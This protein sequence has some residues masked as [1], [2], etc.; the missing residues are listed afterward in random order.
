M[1][2]SVK[3]VLPSNIGIVPVYF[4]YA[5]KAFPGFL[6]GIKNR[7]DEI[8]VKRMERYGKIFC[9]GLIS[10]LE[11]SRK[12]REFF[13][14]NDIDIL[15]VI[16]FGYTNCN[17]VYESFKGLC[18]PVIIFNTALAATVLKDID[19]GKVSYEDGV[20]GVM[21]LASLLKRIE[22]PE[23]HIISGLMDEDGTYSKISKILD[24]VFKRNHR[25]LNYK[26][27]CED[28]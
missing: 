16:E 21:E 27:I 28:F 25:N 17:I 24:Q 11:Q 9:P 26:G 4:E 12:A 23:Y 18:K 13:I 10:N 6:E 15:V 20:V 5:G 8:I 19:F 3:T 22:Y 14:V 1:I 2:K 7:L